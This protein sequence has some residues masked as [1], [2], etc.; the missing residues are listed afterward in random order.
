[1]DGQIL[2]SPDVG[3]HSPFILRS[4]GDDVPRW[5]PGERLHQLFEARVDLGPDNIAVRTAEG[6]ITF[7]EL[8]ARPTGWRI[9]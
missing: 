9:T 7:A 6:N 5:T 2:L 1:M 3:A 4:G 8:D